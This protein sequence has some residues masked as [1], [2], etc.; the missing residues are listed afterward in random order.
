MPKMVSAS[1]APTWFAAKPSTTRAKSAAMAAPTRIPS[2]TPTI[3]ESKATAPAK[4]HTAPMA[5]M[6]STPRLRTPARSATSSPRAATR[7]GVEAATMVSRIASKVVTA[8][9]R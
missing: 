8:V 3:V 1:P 6:P 2:M 5:I 9:P 4:P 7:S